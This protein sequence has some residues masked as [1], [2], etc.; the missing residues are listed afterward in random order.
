[1]NNYSHV[2]LVRQDSDG[3]WNYRKMIPEQETY[4]DYVNKWKDA[5]VFVTI[6]SILSDK[7]DL[8]FL[9]KE[10]ITSA[11]ESN[12]KKADLFFDFDSKNDL[13]LAAEDL[14]SVHNYL[15]N[16]L[17]IEEDD[18][19]IYS[20]G[21]KGFHMLV[22]FSAC[23]LVPRPDLP[24]IYKSF[25]S[26][27]KKNYC[28][29]GTLDLK[30]Y[31]PR[32]LFRCTNT[33]HQETGKRKVR[34]TVDSVRNGKYDGE[35]KPE[36][37]WTGTKVYPLLKQTLLRIEEHQHVKLDDNNRIPKQFLHRPLDCI[38]TVMEEGLPEGIRNDGA[39]TVALY[40]KGLGKNRKETENLLTSSA[41][42][43]K[44]GMDEKELG[45]TVTS[46]FSR[47]HFKFGLTESILEEYITD[48]D[49]ERWSKAKM[50]E[51]YEPF[52]KVV[53]D[54][55]V[56]VET[57]KETLARYN[58]SKLDK[59]LGG[60]NAGELVLVG[61]T[62]GTGKSEFSFQIAYSNAKKGIPAAFITLEVA[63]KDFIG[64]ILRS[65]TG[66]DPVKFWSGDLSFTE[67]RL[68]REEANN[69]LKNDVPLFFRRKRSMMTV[70]E[71]ETIVESLIIEQ[72]CRIIVVDHL[73]YIGSRER[74]I[75]ETTHVSNCV[76]AINN[77][78]VRYG[79]AMLMVAHF[80]KQN[81]PLHRPTL[82]EFRDSSAIEQEAGTVLLL[83]R[84]L[85]AKGDTQY[86]TEVN[87]AKSRK[88]LTLGT[89]KVFWNKN[90]RMYE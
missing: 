45:K 20:T 79:V 9:T 26:S 80:K 60:I 22:R 12:P 57:R 7:K 69:L 70:E 28:R 71:L 18:I 32:R 78:C 10:E 53:R 68:L 1:M 58:V 77:L 3:S 61:G 34:I 15:T 90:T 4:D 14:I 83:W 65:K 89:T 11:F 41:L 48:E 67:R 82:H 62:T 72:H 33:V 5:S 76:R 30:I 29:N 49:R 42:V 54:F 87:L 23:G 17:K 39:F 81:D 13:K 2:E 38:R 86:E 21:N 74:G 85:T 24:D 51:N 63:N 52:S 43:S 36:E 16:S 88:D 6:F 46:A 84:N 37:S 55:V 35:C 25:A 40:W 8:S 50:D 73:H 27:M 56:D 19:R 47:N 31:N 66:I 75:N 44:S 64:R 59:R